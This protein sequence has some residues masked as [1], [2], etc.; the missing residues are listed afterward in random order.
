[1][2]PVMIDMDFSGIEKGFAQEGWG[3]PKWNREMLGKDWGNPEELWVQF[4]KY[5][6]ACKLKNGTK[7]ESVERSHFPFSKAPQAQPRWQ[8]VLRATS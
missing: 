5:R 2:K 8:L 7:P 3:N 6:T 1:M 4:C